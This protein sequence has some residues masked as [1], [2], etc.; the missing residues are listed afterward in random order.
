MSHL[1][2]LHAT[3]LSYRSYTRSPA[4]TAVVAC[5]NLGQ[6]FSDIMYYA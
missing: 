1:K 5:H 4:A 6:D 2:M 3:E